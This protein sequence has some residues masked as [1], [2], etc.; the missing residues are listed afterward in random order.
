MYWFEIMND[1]MK[2]TDSVKLKVQ[3]RHL[4]NVITLN[5]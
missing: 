4:A 5:S 2:N 1:K 3:S